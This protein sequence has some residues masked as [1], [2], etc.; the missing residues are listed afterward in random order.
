MRARYSMIERGGEG[1]HGS[2]SRVGALGSGLAGGDDSSAYVRNV[3]VPVCVCQC[4]CLCA[5]GWS[6]RSKLVRFCRDVRRERG[7]ALTAINCK[8]FLQVGDLEDDGGY[9]VG[10]APS[11]A[12]PVGGIESKSPGVDRVTLYGGPLLC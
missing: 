10:I 5:R 12:K 11:H 7:H 2:P 1:G 8:M 6:W 4:V 9:S 3:N